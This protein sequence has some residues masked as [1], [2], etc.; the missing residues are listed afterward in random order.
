MVGI[1]A[2]SWDGS[3]KGLMDPSATGP[4]RFYRVEVE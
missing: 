3:I 2:G 1:A 4:R